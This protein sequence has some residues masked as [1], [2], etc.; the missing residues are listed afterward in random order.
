MA[1]YVTLI[2]FTDQ[3]VRGIKDSTARAEA[4]CKAA[5]KAGVKVETQLW[6]A[7]SCDGILITSANDAEQALGAV[8]KL[9]AAGNV[10][11]ETMQAFAAA[12]F[13]AITA[14]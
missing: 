2:R 6:T 7:G 13:S 4:F 8:A 12:E 14:K 11:T 10:R 3:G 9:A 5:E 1:R